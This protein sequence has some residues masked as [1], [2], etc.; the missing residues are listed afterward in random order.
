MGF[1]FKSNI[2]FVT[3]T[4]NAREVT[5]K[6]CAVKILRISLQQIPF[7]K[8]SQFIE[9][10]VYLTRVQINQC[11]QKNGKQYLIKKKKKNLWL[12]RGA[13]LANSIT[14]WIRYNNKSQGRD[15]Q[16]KN[17]EYSKSETRKPQVIRSF[18]FQLIRLQPT[19]APKPVNPPAN[20]PVQEPKPIADKPTLPLTNAW[21]ARAQK[22]ET[23]PVETK[24]VE[25][26]TQES[27]VEVDSVKSETEEK[28]K[29]DSAT[30]DSN[31]IP[32]D[33][34][35]NPECKS[36]VKSDSKPD[37]KSDLPSD[38][39]ASE[40]KSETKSDSKPDSK[41]DTKSKPSSWSQLFANVKP[42]Q[43][44]NPVPVPSYAPS[45]GPRLQGIFP[46]FFILIPRTRRNFWHWS[47]FSISDTTSRPHKSSQ[48]MFFERHSASVNFLF[49]ILRAYVAF[50][51]SLVTTKC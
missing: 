7:C 40:P 6:N 11:P 9:N 50:V 17:K 26:P 8:H 12:R 14:H 19:Q 4:S 47:H 51:A 44:S 16:Y 23:K 46:P 48:Q 10:F 38:S 27:K 36:D 31:P 13:I 21:A 25:T 41:S 22:P 15:N 32:S 43:Q 1:F 39:P 5:V 2:L 33:S 18:A 20:L 37:S 45:N 30:T 35:S 34:A 3:E 49:T 29:S 28:P 42:P 24:P